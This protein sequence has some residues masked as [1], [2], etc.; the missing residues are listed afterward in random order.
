[1]TTRQV[2]KNDT[3]WHTKFV[4]IL[5][6][7]ISESCLHQRWKNHTEI[8]TPSFHRKEN[9]VKINRSDIQIEIS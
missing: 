9:N 1:M 8:D 2:Y 4:K 6:E 5:Q 3:Q 7:S